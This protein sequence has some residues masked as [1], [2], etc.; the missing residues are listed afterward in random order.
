[1]A[2]TS[3]YQSND[4]QAASSYRPYRLPVNDILKGLSA[5]D[6]FWDEGARQV[7]QYYDNALNLNLTTDENKDIRNNFMKDANDQMSKLSSMN[8]ADP[9]VQKQG[10]NIFKPLF[11]DKGVMYDDFLTRR[12]GDIFNEAERYKRD[13]KTQ[14]EG[15]NTDNLIY[16]LK[17]FQGFNANTKRGDLEGI[18]QRAKDSE[19]IPY[20]DVSKEYLDLA[21]KCKP[22]KME[23]NSVQGLYF[24]D[25]TDNSLAA[26]KL[27]GCIKSGLSDKG[28][29]QLK[30]TGSVRY[31][32]NYGAIANGYKDILM[33]DNQSYS[34]TLVNL[35][36]ERKKL[37][38]SGQMTDEQ[39]KM[40]DDAEGQFKSKINS[41]SALLNKLSTGDYTDI[42]KD[43]DNIVS[44]VY[45]N[46]DIGGFAQAFSYKDLKQKYQANAAG[47][48][49]MREN[50]EN[51]RFQ[52]GY[53]LNL[54][55]F[56][57]ETAMKQQDQ[58]MNLLKTLLGTNG[59]SG[60]NLDYQT[61]STLLKPIYDN[62]GIPAPDNITSFL[63]NGTVVKDVGETFETIKDK[64]NQFHQERLNAAVGIRNVLNDLGVDLSHVN[65]NNTDELYKAADDFLTTY[66]GTPGDNPELAGKTTDIST[67]RKLTNDYTAARS[68]VWSFMKMRD[69]IQNKINSSPEI[70]AKL[71]DLDKRTANVI[72]SSL[73]NTSLVGKKRDYF[74]FFKDQRKGQDVFL[75]KDD[76]TRLANGT[77]PDYTFNQD[78]EL[79]Y[80]ADGSQVQSGERDK[81]DNSRMSQYEKQTGLQGLAAE[82]GRGVMGQISKLYKERNQTITPVVSNMVHDVVRNTTVF[83]VG[84]VPGLGN[85][86]KKEVG[87]VISDFNSPD[88]EFRPSISY[89]GVTQFDV[90]HKI[91]AKD[92]ETNTTNVEYEKVDAKE[93]MDKLNKSNYPVGG[94][95]NI[96]VT[97]DGKLTIKTPYLP[98][99]QGKY[100]LD[101]VVSNE[102]YGATHLKPA[103]G[104][105]EKRSVPIRN[106][107][108]G[109][110]TGF[111]VIGQGNGRPD[112][113]KVWYTLPNGT[114][115]YIGKELYAENEISNTLFELE[116]TQLARILSAQ[117]NSKNQ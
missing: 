18:Y 67:L 8:L 75:G 77:H 58:Q 90:Y 113:Y 42:K 51:S 116:N 34:S 30:I 104:N 93:V 7:K 25:Q 57:T 49:Q 11:Q 23:S 115:Q 114:K 43:Y 52:M 101:Q 21:S 105:Q 60:G 86:I 111:D 28:W 17:P 38:D 2:S 99:Y 59:V 103:L 24:L 95:N 106:L 84:Q 6:Q 82:N 83:G 3:P 40:Y 73:S 76:L 48:A 64:A 36:A 54:A 81:S 47:I 78:G 50:G 20:H 33:G 79:V 91:K 100:D 41:N 44:Q 61:Y 45:A 96:N 32:D 26:S 85:S 16:A 1:M 35:A 15:Y 5:Q 89:N 68:K 29:Q 72:S 12:Q 109:V 14:G 70:K 62:L 102:L 71:E 22:D 9:S 19:Y 66:D 69:D 55:K 117:K 108:G 112:T 107:N 87:S 110:R 4:Y 39:K 46:Q 97:S 56:Q 94:A 74:L 92:D 10:M 63:D 37:E 98:M 88:Y 65:A 53:N 13:Q 27:Q 31:G 80:K